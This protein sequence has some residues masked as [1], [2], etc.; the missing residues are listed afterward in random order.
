MKTLGKHT[1]SRREALALM[2]GVVAATGLSRL[3]VAQDAAPATPKISMQL[4]TLR[5]PA[6]N[7]LAG[8]LKKVREIGF[9]YVQ[10]SGMP[11][12]PADKIRAALDEAGLKAVSCHCG[13][14]PF[15]TD[16]DNYLAFWKTVGVKFAGP[17]GMMGD[18]Q[19]SLENW[20]AGAKRLDA[21]G[22]KLRDAGIQL[23]FH[24][25]TGEWEKFPGDDRTKEEILAQET[26]PANVALELDLAWVYV[27]GVDPAEAIRRYKGRVPHV[28]AKDVV[29]RGD[30]KPHPVFVP[31]GQGELNWD[32]ILAAGKEAGIEWYAY[33]QDS[34]RGDPFEYTAESYAF[35][36]S[37]LG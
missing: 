3:G 17:G 2:G 34:G 36:K 6:K 19:G 5:E 35:L 37:K 18:A 10:W 14:E 22:A 26:N 25:H 29:L 27:A 1:L 15:E 7:D 31:L 8:T 24:N 32:E 30:K 20:I 23:T 9:E 12:L 28:H 4:Y 11:D 13:V 16:F 33:E 21:V